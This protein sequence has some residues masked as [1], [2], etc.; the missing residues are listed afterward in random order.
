MD[1]VIA[2]SEN[3]RVHTWRLPHGWPLLSF[4]S[5]TGQLVVV[6]VDHLSPSGA[7]WFASA[8]SRSAGVFASEVLGCFGEGEPGWL[9]RGHGPDGRPD[10]TDAAPVFAG[11]PPAVAGARLHSLTHQPPYPGDGDGDAGEVPT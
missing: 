3:A 5:M 7:A 11:D 8:L 9:L 4:A 6:R 10:L 2:P 1:L